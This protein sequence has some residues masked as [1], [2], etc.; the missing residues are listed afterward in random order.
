[1][2]FECIFARKIDRGYFL[3]RQLA[4]QDRKV[5]GWRYESL[6]YHNSIVD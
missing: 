4:S 1:M 2:H 3:L 5:V 6:L